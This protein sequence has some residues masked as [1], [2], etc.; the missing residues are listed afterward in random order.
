M[1]TVRRTRTQSG[2]SLIGGTCGI[3]MMAALFIL[4]AGLGLNAYTYGTMR[5]KLQTA[6]DETAS[7]VNR[8]IYWNGARRPPFQANQHDRIAKEAK[9]FGTAICTALGIDAN[10]V[11]IAIDEQ[12]VNGSSRVTMSLAQFDLPL[13]M[14]GPFPKS[15][16]LSVTGVSTDG[17]EPPPA[18]LRLGYNLIHED[19]VNPANS[20]TV[21]QVVLLPSY[22]FETDLAT[23]LGAANLGG[24]ANNDDV[25]ANQPNDRYCAWNGLNVD[26]K[27]ADD[28]RARILASPPRK[29]NYGGQGYQYLF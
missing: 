2:Q 15:A 10:Q 3:I 14:G 19:T 9:E 16:S 28:K 11:S 4:L 29:K 12:G 21:T 20:T 8:N 23:P 17:S 26:W 1:Q 25:V 27:S 6:A 18:F 22:G 24:T 5:A 7:K 13:G